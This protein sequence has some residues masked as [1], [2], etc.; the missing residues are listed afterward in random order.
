MSTSE[1]AGHFGTSF[2][3]VYVGRV[4][5]PEG[6]EWVTTYEL[7]GPRIRGTVQ[8]APEFNEPYRP[9]GATAWE[10]LPTAFTVAY[11]RS[12]WNRGGASG[13]LEVLGSRLAEYTIV[14]PGQ[15]YNF[16]VRRCESG[17]GD[18]A[19]PRGARDRTR[20]IVEGLVAIHREDERHVHE[21]AVSYLRSRRSARIDDIEYEYRKVDEQLRDLQAQFAALQ[22]RK[23][24]MTSEFSFETAIEDAIPAA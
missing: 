14:R 1:Y 16:S 12:N 19:A 23:A 9:D 7:T 20:E 15:D 13:T 8:I 4:E 24:L 10:F 2:G 21:M 6:R 18:N 3:T 5:S 17:F 11:G 22:H